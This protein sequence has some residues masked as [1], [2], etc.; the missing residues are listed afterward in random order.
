MRISELAARTGTSPRALRYYEEHGL[1]TGRRKSN[2]YRSYDDS[3]VRIVTEIR[4][5]LALGFALEETRPFVEC[6]QSGHPRG[7]SC[8][9]S[10]AVYQRKLAELDGCLDRLQQVREQVDRQLQHAIECRRR[11]PLTEGD[12]A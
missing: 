3:H 1:L 2:G 4:S 12:P 9:D 6:L 5:L 10:V 7:D 11:C 8:P